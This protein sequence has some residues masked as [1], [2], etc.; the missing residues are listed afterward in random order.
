MLNFAAKA[1]LA[2]AL[3]LGSG[4]AYAQRE[5]V[6]N[7]LSKC[8]AGASGPAVMVRVHGFKKSTGRIRVQT[9]PG[10]KAAW[11]KK[12]EWLTR[13][14]VPVSPKGGTM[15]FCLPVPRT[16]TYG[17]AVRHDM[18]GNGKSGWND[19]GGFSGNPDISLFNLEPS[20]SKTAIKVDG[21][22]RISVVLNYRQG[23]SIKP[24]G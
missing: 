19:G 21:V 14:D 1:A 20:V 5:T 6:S 10:T 13:V 17:V 18:D 4:T 24:I 8:A 11:L 3:I 23:M 9:Y 22:T 2:M 7:D 16:G 12:G 15:D